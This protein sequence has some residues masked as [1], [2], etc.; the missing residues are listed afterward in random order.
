MVRLFVGFSGVMPPFLSSSLL[1]SGCLWC[2]DQTAFPVVLCR[3]GIAANVDALQD[4][5]IVL[6]GPAKLVWHIVGS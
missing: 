1:A 2:R 3:S 6:V 5:V 4:I